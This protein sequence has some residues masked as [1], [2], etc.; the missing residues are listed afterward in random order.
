MIAVGGDGT[1]LLAANLIFDNKKPIIGINSDP[2]MSEGYLMLDRQF[3]YDI[4]SIFD[5]LKTGSFDY[6]MRTRIRVT[7][8]GKGI[9]GLPFHMHEKS[10]ICGQEM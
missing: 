7:L 5:K 2:D 8:K 4:P 9:W 1:F 3:T 6:L 10:R